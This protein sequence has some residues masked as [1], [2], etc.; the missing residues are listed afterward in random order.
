[1][2]ALDIPRDRLHNQ[3]LSQPK[4]TQPTEIVEWLGAVQAQDYAGAKWALGL[5]I[6]GATD[7]ALD[8]AFNEG[9]ILRTHVMRPTWH[10]VTPEDIRWMLALT[11]PRVHLANAY[12]YRTLELDEV[13]LKKSNATLEKALQ[14]G[15]QLTRSELLSI[16][17]NAG[18][19]ADRGRL[20]YF[21]IYAELEGLICSG[22]RRG[23][24]FTYAL[25]DERAP[26]AK[27][28]ERDEALAELTKR[29]FRSHGPATLQD[30]VWWSGLSIN[31]ARKGIDF[32]KSLLACE[33]IDDQ[34]YYFS[35]AATTST[36]SAVAHLLPNYDEYMV[37]YTDRDSIFD[38][39][40][41]GKLDSRGNILFQ[42]ALML[43]GRVA[44]TWKRTIK[45]KEVV[46]NLSPFTT[47]TRDQNQAIIAATQQYG[48]F[49]D[50]PVVLK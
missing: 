45:K 32:V 40:H 44:G 11:S 29:Y 43:N 22:A 5:R 14:G 17:K 12:A 24:Q 49:L 3:L 7:A 47:L 31:D 6:S 1:M 19:N 21:L 35:N 42:Y 4:W 30:F 8:Q 23:K 10:F 48:K 27:I 39:A 18:I 38:G 46:I 34:S 9:K 50:L 20:G 16:F 41:A 37:G 2:M 33:T 13:I 28:L 36:P 15:K 25:V 26:Q